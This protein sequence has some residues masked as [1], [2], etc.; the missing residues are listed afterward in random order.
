MKLNIYA[1]I[2]LLCTFLTA[3]AQYQLENPG[4]ENWEDVGL[5]V[6]ER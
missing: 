4:F 6:E 1:L 3:S 2:L 5:P